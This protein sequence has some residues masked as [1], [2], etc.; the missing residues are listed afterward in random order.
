LV[1]SNALRKLSCASEVAS[2][3]SAVT[4][5]SSATSRYPVGSLE[6]LAAWAA[7]EREMAVRS[8]R[9]AA[10]HCMNAKSASTASAAATV[11]AIS[12]REC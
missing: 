6:F 2:I 5:C 3:C 1:S 9:R 8:S 11:L 10:R 4:A 12:V 7:S